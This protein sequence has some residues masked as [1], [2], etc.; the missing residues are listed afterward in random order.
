MHDRLKVAFDNLQHGWVALSI[1][2]G[3]KKVMIIASYTPSDSFL[4][5]TNALHGL[6]QYEGQMTITWHEEPGEF[7][8]RF[9]QRG[10]VIRLEIVG[11]PDHGRGSID[12]EIALD[13]SGVYEEMCIPFWR[14]L[15]DL[16]G[17]FT[18]E[19]LETRWHRPFP[20]KE[21]SLLTEAIRN[22]RS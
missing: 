21:L 16:Q 12:G 19:E 7:D 1:S 15:R 9:L 10:K 2:Y 3:D 8:M 6:L 17:R 22:K 11:Y 13:I 5:L 18:A 14:A 4:D 20:S